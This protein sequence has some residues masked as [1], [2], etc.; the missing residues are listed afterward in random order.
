MNGWMRTLRYFPVSQLSIQAS[1]LDVD[2]CSWCSLFWCYE[3]RVTQYTCLLYLLIW[4]LYVGAALVCALYYWR[5]LEFFIRGIT[6]LNIFGCDDSARD[7]IGL[8]CF[9][10]IWVILQSVKIFSKTLNTLSF[11]KHS[12]QCDALPPRKTHCCLLFFSIGFHQS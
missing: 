12:E 9:F 3:E 10:G 6:I 1:F 4:S 11:S 8:Q 5:S 7:W 2:W